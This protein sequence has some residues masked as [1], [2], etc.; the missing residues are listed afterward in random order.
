MTPGR[1][2]LRNTEIAEMAEHLRKALG[3][4]LTAEEEE[5]FVLADQAYEADERNRLPQSKAA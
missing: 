4:K 2:T 5:F 3:R 1:S